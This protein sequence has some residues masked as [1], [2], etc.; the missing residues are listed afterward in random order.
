MDPQFYAVRWLTTLFARE[1]PLTDTFR[2]W[3]S[4]LADPARFMLMYCI[5]A[6]MIEHIEESLL[7]ADFAG[8]MNL[9]QQYQPPEVSELLKTADTI[10]QSALCPPEEKKGRDL[11]QMG[12]DLAGGMGVQVRKGW[13]M[14]KT[15]GLPFLSKIGRRWMKECDVAQ[16]TKMKVASMSKE[17]SD[18]V[19]QK[20]KERKDNDET[21]DEKKKKKKKHSHEKKS[22][23]KSETNESEESE[24]EEK[25][26]SKETEE[27]TE[28]D[29]EVAYL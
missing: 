14:M 10:R 28:E 24:T 2:V 13:N 26:K 16:D 5:G 12:A 20:L 9:L 11:K 7:Q 22:L 1:F 19:N 3:D 21:A 4:L 23:K 15:K 17:V 8:I 29:E 25:P 27:E 18:T 6:A